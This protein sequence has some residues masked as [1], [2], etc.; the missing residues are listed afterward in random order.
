[1]LTNNSITFR[2]W[3]ILFG[4]IHLSEEKL[5]DPSAVDL[6]KRMLESDPASRITINGVLRHPYFWKGEE[7]LAFII[8][9][10]DEVLKP[11]MA[12]VEEGGESDIINQL[13]QEERPVI[14]GYWKQFLTPY[15]RKLIDRRS[16]DAK[17]L[18][19]LLLAVR[20][21]VLYSDTK[22]QSKM[23]VY[24]VKHLFCIGLNNPRAC[25]SRRFS[26]LTSLPKSRQ[27]LEVS[28]KV[29]GYTGRRDSRLYP[30]TRG[31]FLQAGLER[32]NF[33]SFQPFLLFNSHLLFKLVR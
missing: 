19:G 10:V 31:G 27:S 22:F 33:Q 16:Y 5:N 11:E 12:K 30:S 25:I 20:D 7:A 14:R 17:S 3:S 32:F 21:K 23:L 8:K 29:T 9:A 13:K 24:T 4:F 18:T 15:I 28:R 6:I 26:M 1:M 2:W